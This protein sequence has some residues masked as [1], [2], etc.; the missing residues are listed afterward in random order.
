MAGLN[1]N[2]T[3]CN[4]QYIIIS[5]FNFLSSK[6]KIQS[7]HY[8]IYSSNLFLLTSGGLGVSLHSSFA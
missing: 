3:D 5:E 7:A 8:L 4:I 1:L 2:I 6:Y